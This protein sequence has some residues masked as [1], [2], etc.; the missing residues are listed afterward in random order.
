[1]PVLINHYQTAILIHRHDGSRSRMLGHDS[2]GNVAIRRLHLVEPQIDHA[3]K[4]ILAA[5]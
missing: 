3:T 2:L 4:K 1:M 5:D